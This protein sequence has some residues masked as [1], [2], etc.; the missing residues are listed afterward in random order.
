[1]ASVEYARQVT[2]VNLRLAQ[3]EALLS[4][5]E[6]RLE[7]LEDVAREQGKTAAHRLE[8]FDDVS[9]EV[10]HL[11]GE[12]ERIDH[13]LDVL[14]EGTSGAQ[15]GQERRQIYDEMRLDQLEGFLGVQPPDR[16][17]DLELGL[18]M[19]NEEMEETTA[20]SSESGEQDTNE[21]EEALR[22][23]PDTAKAKLQLAQ[24]HVEDERH[25]LART[26][27]QQAIDAHPK[28]S[29]IPE[30]RFRHAMTFLLEE[31]WRKAAVAFNRVIDNHPSSTWAPWAMLRQGE[32]FDAMGQHDNARLFYEAVIQNYPKSDASSDAKKALSR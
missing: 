27:L 21:E 18:E 4:A 1:M 3:L 16:P 12:I 14:N 17:S 23:L 11:R 26:V 25:V 20:D 2:A 6:G 13:A 7:Q 9:T 24:Q 8:S 19:P 28:A 29:E 32:C 5:S 30:I 10:A 15:I 22:E 31:D